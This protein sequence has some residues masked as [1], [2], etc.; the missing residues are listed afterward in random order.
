MQVV[1]PAQRDAGDDDKCSQ[2]ND[3]EGVS[4]INSEAMGKCS[5]PG[6]GSVHELCMAT[7]LNL[8]QV[9]LPLFVFVCI[10]FP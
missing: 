1:S 4:Q 6:P 2:E 10:Y 8:P 9:F 7:F 3:V 5:R